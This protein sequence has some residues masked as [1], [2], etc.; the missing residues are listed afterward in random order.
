[1]KEFRPRLYGEA[2]ESIVDLVREI[3]PDKAVT[4]LTAVDD[5]KIEIDSHYNTIASDGA[6][7]KT[8]EDLL[9]AAEVNLEEWKVDRHVINKW[10]TTAK[11]ST[12]ELIQKA[13]WQVKAW[14]SRRGIQH[15]DN[16]WTEKWLQEF[17]KRIPKRVTNPTSTT[18]TGKPFVVVVADTHIGAIQAD[19]VYQTYNVDVCREK[20][21]DVANEVNLKADGPVYVFHMGDIIESFTGKNK[22]DTWKQIQMHGAEVALTAYDLLDEFFGSINNFQECYFIGG[23]HD[24]ITDQKEGDSDGQVAQI[25]HG[26]F[27]RVG[28]YKT[29][30][31]P[32]LQV[33][34]LD[35]ISYILTHGDKKISSSTPEKLII[36]YG[37]SKLY[38]VILSAHTHNRSDIHV[39]TERYC[40]IK[41][42]SIVPS[43]KYAVS[44]GHRNATGFLMM[45]E[46][47]GKVRQ[48][49]IPL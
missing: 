9:A 35:N 13:N 2:W 43:N 22:G 25:I 47:N 3:G 6:N 41:A 19:G 1:M 39:D 36:D 44:L 45:E 17:S 12:G 34:E 20:L 14:L 42:P 40:S 31:D 33:V 30:F 29:H 7:I 32:L 46:R 49:Y 21:L 37:N 48:E 18:H 26:I 5:S 23:N 27:E 11:T 28:Q 15:P 38:T 4:I 24:R 16:F 8:L 10:P